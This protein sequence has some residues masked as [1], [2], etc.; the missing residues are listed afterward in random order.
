[1]T[2]A[3]MNMGGVYL[4][5][6]QLNQHSGSGCQVMAQSTCNNRSLP[7]FD[8]PYIVQIS[9]TSLRLLDG[10]TLLE[11]VQLTNEWRI[12]LVS[13]ADPFLLLSTEDDELYLLRLRDPSTIPM[14][15]ESRLSGTEPGSGLDQ[16]AIALHQLDAL[17]SETESL[18]PAARS[19]QR[20]D[21]MDVV[22]NELLSDFL[23]DQLPVSDYFDISQPK[24][25]QVSAPLCFCLYYDASGK[26]SE[27]LFSEN[28]FLQS[29]AT[30][31]GGDGT[32]DPRRQTRSGQRSGQRF[33]HEEDSPQV[34]AK[35]PSE[36]MSTAPPI[37]GGT[38][39]HPTN[40]DEEDILLYGEVIHL[41][42]P[43]PSL[44]PSTP[45]VD[46]LDC[47]NYADLSASRVTK[48]LDERDSFSPSTLNERTEPRPYSADAVVG[49]SHY[50]AF[51]AYTNGVLEPNEVL[52]SSEAFDT[53]MVTVVDCNS[54]KTYLYSYKADF[55]TTIPVDR[56]SLVSSSSERKTFEDH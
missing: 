10:A 31:P 29:V 8:Y 16:E 15:L 19:P 24:V 44:V 14:R 32:S 45:V 50:L 25:G 40:S 12:H 1:M 22:E 52:D 21:Q 30:N 54:K 9:P 17:K 37:V 55:E 7:P 41:V 2:V 26:L 23:I 3:A 39:G 43:E 48:Q 53:N 34:P 42:K 33:D 49:R 51:I 11:H 56:V 20:P 38:F 4:N 36:Q 18:S 5:S 13:C 46:G 28:A 35:M 47:V 6:V 27:M